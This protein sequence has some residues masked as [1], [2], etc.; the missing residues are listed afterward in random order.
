MSTQTK[1]MVPQA[2]LVAQMVKNPP[3]MMETWIHPWVGKIPWRRAW[4]PT[5]VFLENPH[6]QRSLA[7]YSPWVTKSQTRLSN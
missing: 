2:S 4:K 5:S 6:G 3:A 1:L 7:G